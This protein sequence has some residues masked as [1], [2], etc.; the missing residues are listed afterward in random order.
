MTDGM[1]EDA[2]DRQIRDF[3]A[4]QA[5]KTA[6]AP[7]AIEMAARI[8]AG[9]GTRASGLRLTPHLV[10]VVLAGLLTVALVGTVVIGAGLLQVSIPQQTPTPRPSPTA[11]VS[12]PPNQSIV[13]AGTTSTTIGQLSWTRVQ[14]DSTNLPDEDI[15]EIP[16]GFGSIEQDPDLQTSRFWVSS[17]GV[18]W[19]VAPMPVPA[20]SQV[21]HWV[22]SAGH[23]MW[24]G[25]DFRLW[26]SSD[27]VTW[28]EVAL[29]GLE[30]PAVDGVDWLVSP[31][32]APVTVGTTTVLPWSASGRL[33][34]DRLLGFELEP[35]EQWELA[36]SGPPL[37]LGTARDV[38]RTRHPQTS[39]RSGADP[40]RVRVGSIRVTVDGS[41]V[42]IT[43]AERDIILAR[44]DSD[45]VGIPALTLAGNIN[46]EGDIGLVLG[47]AAISDG[48]ARAF[49]PP[50]D[51]AD[52]FAA[53]GR[54][55]G[56]TYPEGP[57][58]SQV[59]WASTNGLDWES[60]GPPAVPLAGTDIAHFD[61]VLRRPGGALG[62]PLVVPV[63]IDEAGGGQRKELWSSV[64]GLTWVND[65]LV[66]RFNG[67]GKEGLVPFFA[68]SGSFLATG[69]D[70]RLHVSPDGSDW[71]TVN[72]FEVVGTDPNQQGWGQLVGV[73][74]EATFIADVL[75][76]GDRMLYVVRIEPGGG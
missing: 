38:F 7:S 18:Q 45:V 33:A 11:V 49:T 39:G 12:A 1:R 51:F 67:T 68:P 59:V 27:F 37:P 66:Y 24:S 73:T 47:G 50:G 10:W 64:D 25:A 42:T 20:T 29:T 19:A 21:R 62:E 60:L 53:Q 8:G 36:F 30:P 57:A 44:I 40:T 2:F 52:L 76:N 15:F 14:G 17:D 31:F 72:G 32:P 43:D 74:Q 56:M 69:D 28:T 46:S 48:I 13:A 6:G 58:S 9:V 4:W 34:L 3:L 54:I 75:D 26:Q 41:F 63:L 65:G 35:G 55:V 22:T 16:D 71:S 23:W 70:F 5:A 61:S